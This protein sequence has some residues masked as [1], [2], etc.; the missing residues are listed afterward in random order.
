MQTG[1]TR[2]AG[3]AGRWPS[4]GCHVQLSLSH[5]ARW[6]HFHSSCRSYSRPSC[7]RATEAVQAR[8]AGQ[9]GPGRPGARPPGRRRQ[10]PGRIR[11][12][13]HRGSDGADAS[14]GMPDRA[15]GGSRTE[16]VRRGESG[17]GSGPGQRGRGRQVRAGGPI[18]PGGVWGGG[19]ADQQ[20]RAPPPTPPQCRAR[21]L[22]ARGAPR[23]PDARADS[24]VFRLGC[25]GRQ[26]GGPYCAV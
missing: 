20:P 10:P 19:G 12:R 2:Q 26:A 9:A 18:S 13:W 7:S 14:P 23:R 11:G 3:Q 4:H 6:A 5:P 22:M 1:Q 24:D 21:L 16:Q 8:Q 15:A 25:A 17:A